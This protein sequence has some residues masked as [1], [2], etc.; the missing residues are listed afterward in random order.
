LDAVRRRNLPET[1][2]RIFD[3]KHQPSNEER[4]EP[5]MRS[6]IVVMLA[7]AAIG[8]LSGCCAKFTHLTPGDTYHVGDTITSSQ[9]D[10]VVEQFQWSGGTWTNSGTAKVDDRNYARGSG[11]DLNARNV[12]L[13]FQFDYPIDKIFLKFGELGGNNNIR[14]NSVFQNVADLITLNG[15]S[16]DAVQITVN[17]NQEGNNW[18]GTLELNGTINDFAIGGQ[19]LWL[20]DVC[21]D[22]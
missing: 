16:I 22:N 9:V 6:I 5:I 11:N 21:P 4:R 2:G 15:N 12:N 17:A 13:N 10:I 18:Y 3:Q 19:E 1:E 7:T 20:D 14:V 8:L